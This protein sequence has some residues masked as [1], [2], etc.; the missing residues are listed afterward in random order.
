M[1]EQFSEMITTRVDLAQ[2]LEAGF[3]SYLDDLADGYRR[4]LAPVVEDQ[5]PELD[6]GHHIVLLGRS[7]RRHRRRDR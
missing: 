7:V 1:A 5:E 6:P 4:Y 3:D 2:S